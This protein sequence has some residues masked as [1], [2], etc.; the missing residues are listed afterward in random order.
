MDQVY[1]IDSV[2]HMYISILLSYENKRANKKTL[3]IINVE[4]TEGIDAYLDPLKQLTTF[5]DVIG[6]KGASA[7]LALKKDANKFDSFFRRSSTLKKMFEEINPHINKYHDFISKAEINLFHIIMSKAYFLVKFPKNKFRMLEEGIGTYTK[8]PRKFRRFKR[9]VMGFPQLMG[10][11]KQV[12]EILV[13]NPEKMIDTKLRSKSH[14]LDLEY[15]LNR[16]S[17][18]EKRAIISAFNLEDLD[19]YSNKKKVLIL[20]QPLIKSGFKVTPEEMI[21]IYKKFIDNALSKDMEV[22]FKLHPR[23]EIDYKSVFE[24]EKIKIIP[25]LIPIEILNMDSS[26][27]FDEAYTICSGAIFNLKHVGEIHFLGMDYLDRK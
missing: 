16:L 15:L 7:V 23:E 12:K 10:Y 20:T 17:D 2:Y 4:G 11:D 6:V 24:N 19:V 8:K 9:K 14:K 18:T 5:E 22:Y 25:N 26:I 21:S 1:V 27:Y 13:Q 3:L